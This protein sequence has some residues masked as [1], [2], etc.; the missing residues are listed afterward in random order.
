MAYYNKKCHKPMQNI[1]NG[2]GKKNID[3][4]KEA[5]KNITKEM[6]N[7]NLMRGRKDFVYLKMNV[8]VT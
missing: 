5:K 2:T 7:L 3:N 8:S 6:V 4:Y 1:A